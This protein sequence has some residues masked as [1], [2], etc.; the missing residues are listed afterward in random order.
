MSKRQFKTQASSGRAGSAF[1]GFGS[2]GFGTGQSSVLSFV[3]EPPDYSS[4][5]DANAIVAF[6]NL[7]KKDEVTKAKAL[8]ELQT[9]A[10][11]SDGE[12]SEPFLEA[13][14]STLAIVNARLDSD[15]EQPGSTLPS[16]FHRQCSKSTSACPY[17]QWTD[18]FKVWQTDGETYAQNSWTLARWNI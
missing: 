17:A 16:T 1:G 10:S 11:P 5:S 3:Q 14:V 7:S 12:V 9:Y 2:P 4:I 6:K 18:M 13:W 8:E 15:R